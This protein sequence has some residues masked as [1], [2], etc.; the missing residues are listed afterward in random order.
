MRNYEPIIPK[1]ELIDGS[2]YYGDCRN[3]SVARWDGQR[4]VFV[5]WRSKFG[6]T[7]LEDIKCPEDDEVYDVFIAE[8]IAEEDDVLYKIPIQRSLP[9]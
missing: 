6:D 1:K 9:F 5:Y 8:R 3:A 7:F 4:E 2:Y